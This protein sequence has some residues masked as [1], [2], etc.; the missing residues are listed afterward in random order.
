MVYVKNALG[1]Y[2]GVN[3]A[4]NIAALSDCEVFTQEQYH[5]FLLSVA[6]RHGITVEDVDCSLIIIEYRDGR[7]WQMVVGYDW[8]EL[9]FEGLDSLEAALSAYAM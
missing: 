7:Y 5:D 1:H 9:D 4:L 2:F 6:T 3:C 8:H